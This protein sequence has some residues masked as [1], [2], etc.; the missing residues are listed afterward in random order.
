M[1]TPHTFGTLHEVL[2]KYDRFSL[3]GAPQFEHR[4]WFVRGG[5]HKHTLIVTNG[6]RGVRVKVDPTL[7]AGLHDTRF[8]T[9]VSRKR[10]GLPA[11]PPSEQWQTIFNAGL[12][13]TRYCPKVAVK[14]LRGF[15]RQAFADSDTNEIPALQFQLLDGDLYCRAVGVHRG[16]VT[17]R[18]AE[19]S[20]IGR[21]PNM[22]PDDRVEA[23]LSA[24]SVR[25]ALWGHKP[26][27]EVLVGVAPFPFASRFLLGPEEHIISPMRV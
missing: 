10:P 26:S 11:C 25:N 17:D 6:H 1:D 14:V 7:P 4:G 3:N 2:K 20:I 19:F 22:E 9:R 8:G 23:V 24:N 16:W 21:V 5:K 18:N 15:I 12:S 13:E 27:E